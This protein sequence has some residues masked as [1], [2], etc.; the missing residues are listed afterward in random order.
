MAG[1]RRVISWRRRFGVAA[2]L[3]ALAVAAVAAVVVGVRVT[4]QDQPVA[5]PTAITPTATT[6]ATTRTADARDVGRPERLTVKDIRVDAPVKPVG[7]TADGAQ[8]VPKSIDDTGWW[9]DGVQPGKSGNAVIVGHTASSDDGVFDDLGKLDRGDEVVVRSARGNLR[10][11]VTRLT[12]VKV[13]DFSRISPAVYRETGPPGLVLM[14]CGDWN[15]KE[16]ETT[17]IV[18]SRLLAS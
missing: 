11:K 5:K 15:G 18:F 1:S 14:T 8:D 9:R 4:D 10:Y 6:A 7:T 13:D 3:V 2:V 17:T 16:F 12:S